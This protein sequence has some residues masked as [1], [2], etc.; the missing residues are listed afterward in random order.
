MLITHACRVEE[1][2]VDRLFAD[3]KLFERGIVTRITLTFIVDGQNSG[4]YSAV[5]AARDN[6][7]MFSLDAVCRNDAPHEQARLNVSM[8]GR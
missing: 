2:D 3:R 4:T 8:P 5:I 7:E 6:E 1:A